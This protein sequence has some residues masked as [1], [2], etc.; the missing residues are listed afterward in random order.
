MIQRLSTAEDTRLY[1]MDRP[2]TPS[3][4]A[5]DCRSSDSLEVVDDQTTRPNGP[6]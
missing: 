5:V 1:H 6:D 2:R 4:V 3:L